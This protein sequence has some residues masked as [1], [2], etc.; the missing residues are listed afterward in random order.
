MTAVALLQSPG[1]P[2]A[3]SGGGA[4]DPEWAGA[5]LRRYAAALAEPGLEVIV[6]DAGAGGP[7]SV[8]IADTALVLDECAGMLPLGGTERRGEVAAV[9]QRLAAYRP[10][11]WIEPP[12]RLAGGDIVRVGR[13]LYVGAGPDSD[14]DGIAALAHCVEPL[15]YQLEPVPVFGCRQL[16]GGVTALGDAAVVIN[17]DWVDDAAFAGL[18]RFRVAPQEPWA[19]NTLTIG[20]TTLVRHDAPQ[21]ARTLA[22]SGFATHAIDLGELAG[23]E[24][25]PACLSL[26]LAPR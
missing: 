10:L 25:G 23:A 12:A 18:R 5:A 20:A 24:G 8:A 7:E 17:P 13:T 15:G 11:T 26:V 19:A 21:T 22:R 16:T 14:P 2:P 1:A 9:A 6:A 4:G 3:G